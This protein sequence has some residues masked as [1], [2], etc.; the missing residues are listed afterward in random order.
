MK[1]TKNKDIEEQEPMRDDSE[2]SDQRIKRTRKP[3]PPRQNM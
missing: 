1:K 3:D 2:A